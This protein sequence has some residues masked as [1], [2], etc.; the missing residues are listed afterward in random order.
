[1]F[2]VK[3]RTPVEVLEFSWGIAFRV[4]QGYLCLEIILFNEAGFLL[5]LSEPGNQSGSSL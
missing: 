4:L 5:D 2:E 1:M 3:L